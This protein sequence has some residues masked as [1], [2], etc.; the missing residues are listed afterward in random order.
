[1]WRSQADLEVPAQASSRYL[2]IAFSAQEPGI[3]AL[4]GGIWL[5]LSEDMSN[6]SPGV[7]LLLVGLIGALSSCTGSSGSQEADA[8]S[9]AGPTYYRDVEPILYTHCVDC[10]SEGGIAPFALDTPEAAINSAASIALATQERVMPPWPPGEDSVP[11]LHSRSLEA[12]QIEIL[13]AW[14]EAGAPLG[15]SEDVGPRVEPEIVDIGEV[16]LS[17]DIGADYVPDGSVT[18]D[19]RCFLADTGATTLRAATGYRVVPGN[20]KTVHHVVTGLFPASDRSTLD[21]LDAESAKAGWPCFSG[22]IPEGVEVTPIGSIGSWV[23]GVSAVAYPEGTGNWV[24]A[25][26]VA[27]IQ[28]HY[29]LAGGT[30]PDRTRIEVALAPTGESRTAL[31]GLRLN[32]R[33]LDI[34]A[35]SERAE[36]ET[37]RSAEEWVVQRGG[38]SFPDGDGYILT[39]SMHAHLLATEMELLL[40]GEPILDIPRWDF[41][42]QGSYQLAEPIRVQNSDLLTIRCVYNNSDS[43][44]ASQGM[45]PT[46]DVG[47]GEGTEDE[48]CLGAFAVVDE[49]P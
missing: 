46:V 5:A 12:E 8:G 27:V 29:N 35:A 1:M 30:D 31:R 37:T 49:L 42:W 45:G 25:N 2:Q 34:P 22:L 36:H 41:H 7:H 39:A 15:D 24:P 16:E 6:H 44:R 13:S 40:N 14:Y 3:M 48:M 17:F 28:I 4:C 23:P 10:H 47:W 43:F 19:Y 9:E 11:M 20:E 21:A 33:Q 18:D 26:S 32:H 38:Q